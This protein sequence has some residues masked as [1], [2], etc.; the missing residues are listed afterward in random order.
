MGQLAFTTE[1][2]KDLGKAPYEKHWY[3]LRGVKSGELQLAFKYTSPKKEDD[4]KSSNN[5]GN[6]A[7]SE[8]REATTDDTLPTE[9]AASSPFFKKPQRQEK[10]AVTWGGTTQYTRTEDGVQENDDG[11]VFTVNYDSTQ[12]PATK[13][14]ASFPLSFRPQNNEPRSSSRIGGARENA[15][16]TWSNRFS[17]CGAIGPHRLRAR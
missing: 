1:K 11:D 2:L 14:R 8:D 16:G 7:S 9:R 15:L 13:Q 4:D 17:R 3:R 10:S 5:G 6:L 12:F